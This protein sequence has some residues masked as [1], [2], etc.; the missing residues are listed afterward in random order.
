MFFT[1]LHYV[2]QVK[3][4]EHNKDL[5]VQVSDWFSSD[6][7]PQKH[8]LKIEKTKAYSLWYRKKHQ[9][10]SIPFK[11]HENIAKHTIVTCKRQLQACD[12]HLK[13]HTHLLKSFLSSMFF[14]LLHYVFAGVHNVQHVKQR[15]ACNTH[16]LLASVN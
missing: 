11:L 3:L 9:K 15:G 5:L 14:T 6:S 12:I 8:L 7:V 2:Q 4:I 13:D 10:I 16:V 1:L